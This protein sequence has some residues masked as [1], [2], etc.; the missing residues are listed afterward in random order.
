MSALADLL[1]LTEANPWHK[2]D[3]T[4]GLTGNKGVWSFYFKKPGSPRYI[5]AKGPRGVKKKRIPVDCGRSDRSVACKVSTRFKKPV[6]RP[7][8]VGKLKPLAQRR[9]AAKKKRARG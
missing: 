3:G 5:G 4:F 1:S 7:K 9:A 8:P 2:A 6:R